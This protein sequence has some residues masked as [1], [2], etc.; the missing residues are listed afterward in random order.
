MTPSVALAIGL[1]AGGAAFFGSFLLPKSRRASDIDPIARNSADTEILLVDC[2]VADMTG[3]ARQ[4]LDCEPNE[5][6]V[7]PTLIRRLEP[8]FGPLPE[9]PPH[10]PASVDSPLFP[11]ARL[12]IFP[13]KDSLRLSVQAD[14][15]AAGHQIRLRLDQAEMLRLRRAMALVPCPI[16]QS[17]ALG[18]VSWFNPAYEDVCAQIGTAP[19]GPA[20]FELAA[21]DGSDTRRS[22]TAVGP[23]GDRAQLWYEVQ[24]HRTCDGWLHV[25]TN[26]DS[27]IHSEVT[28]RNFLQTLT[29]IFAHLPIGLAVF[30]RERRLALFNPALID[31]VHL[32][33]EFLSTRPNLMSFFDALR[34]GRMMPEP[35]NYQSWRE[36]LS[37]VIAA[38]AS[39]LYVETWELPSGLTY[40]ITGRPHPDGGIAFLFEDISSEISLTRRFRREIEQAHSVLDQFED[41]VAVFSDHGTLSL[42]NAAYRTLWDDDP[43]SR[44]AD[45]SVAEAT[46]RWQALCAPS[47]V[48]GEIRDFVL[49]LRERAPWEAHL[50]LHTGGGLLCRVAPMAGGATLVRFAPEETGATAPA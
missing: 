34:E 37:E 7:W 26:I 24:S 33:A 38:A 43:D 16:W 42:C 27:V 12:S 31:L 3:A 10:T 30:D 32:E 47:P 46:A 11:E 23:R 13:A 1:G 21:P 17:D 22:R 35:K 19:D 36:H 8:V 41:A 18:Q 45:L 48:W 20:P 6:L 29:R 40:R 28:Q 2:Q 44:V 39:D 14:Y 49:C 50:R 9:Q 4:M 15:L 25:A 5:D